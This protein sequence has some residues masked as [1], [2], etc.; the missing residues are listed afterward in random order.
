MI[1]IIVYCFRGIL[2]SLNQGFIKKNS[3][4]DIKFI[5]INLYQEIHLKKNMFFFSNNLY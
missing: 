2:I 5:F 3:S 1:L 4:F